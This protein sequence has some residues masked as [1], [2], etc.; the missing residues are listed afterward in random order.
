MRNNL[1]VFAPLRHVAATGLLA[2]GIGLAA[3]APAAAQ[4]KE[5]NFEFIK[6]DPDLPA[7]ALRLFKDK[8]TAA[9]VQ[10]N[11]GAPCQWTLVDGALEVKPGTGDIITKQNFGDFLLHVEF[12]T[13]NMPN[14][15]G[16]A[17]G[18]SGVYLHGR[19][20]IQILDSYNLPP[21]KVD[22]GAIYEQTA[23]KTNAA[24][25]PLKWQT[26]DITFHAPRF[27][28][29]GTLT[30]KPRVTVIWNGRKVHDNVEILAPTRA[31][32]EAPM[33]PVGP[34]MLQDHGNT[35]RFRNV[36]IKPL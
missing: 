35:V 32:M 33:P 2:L 18:N 7:G 30:A 14:A 9:W 10:R 25:P 21:T 36:W 31:G 15:R 16:Q 24:K 29:S 34:I 19:Y 12:M 5:F 17:R 8:D 4:N 1:A 26:Y 6:P 20:E 22:C 3:L 11:G 27:D 23:P 13:P 28:A